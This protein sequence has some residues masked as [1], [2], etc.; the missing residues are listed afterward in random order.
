M[1]TSLRYVQHD[2]RLPPVDERKVS[3]VIFQR[4]SNLKFN[5]VPECGLQVATNAHTHILLLLLFYLLFSLTRT[6]YY[7]I[8]FISFILLFFAM[9][10]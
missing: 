3:L 5:Q 6:F 9:S 7:F 2:S 10:A 8:L 4:E 1:K